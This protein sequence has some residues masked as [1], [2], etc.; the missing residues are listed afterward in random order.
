MD[1]TKSTDRPRWPRPVVGLALAVVACGLV[2][3][4]LKFSGIGP[5]VVDF[6]LTQLGRLQQARA[7]YPV[8]VY[9]GAFLLYVVVAGLSLPGAAVMTLAYG[10]MFGFWRALIL[11]SFSSTAG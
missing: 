1:S 5:V 3:S 7:E 11:V 10:W 8:A 6:L 4:A 2:V 9:A